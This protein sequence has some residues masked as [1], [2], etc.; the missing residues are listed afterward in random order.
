MIG[1]YLCRLGEPTC[2][3]RFGMWIHRV[4]HFPWF[5]LVQLSHPT[6][7]GPIDAPF[8]RARPGMSTSSCHGPRT[9]SNTGAVSP[10]GRPRCS[11]AGEAAKRRSSKA[12]RAVGGFARRLP[13]TWF[14][15]WNSL[16]HRGGTVA[17]KSQGGFLKQSALTEVERWFS[18]KQPA[19]VGILR[20]QVKC[21]N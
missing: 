21:T 16:I 12:A 4:F 6:R 13:G 18:S 9:Q 1:D 17:T 7:P 8:D 11:G 14:V 20:G 2:L 5:F 15:L 3:L 10:C 19:A